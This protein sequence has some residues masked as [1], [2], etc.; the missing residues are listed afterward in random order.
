M[1]TVHTFTVKPSL[2]EQ[3]KDLQ[4]IVRNLY[5]TWHY[6]ITEIFRRIDYDLWKQCIH[7]PVKMLGMVSQARLEDLARNE[8][9][10]YQLKQA[11]E[12]LEK[13]LNAPSW[14]NKIYAREGH[15]TLIAYFCAEFGIHESM[16]IYSGGLGMLSGDHLKSASDL[17]I[18]LVGVGLMY[19]KGYFRQ[20]LNTDGWQQEH[21]ID[22]DFHNMPLELVQKENGHPVL[23][24]IQF[25]DR[26]VQAQIW[27]AMI[28]RTPLYLL[29]T[30]LTV[31]SFHD[32]TITQTLY[33]G[34]SEMRICQEIVLGIGG[35][36]ALFA[37]GLEPTVCHMNEG[38]AAFMAL[39]RVRKLRSRY[40]MTFE[41]ALEAARASN[42]FTVHTPVAAGND[43]FPVEMIDKYFSHYYGTLGINR[44]QFLALGRVHP[45]DSH[46][47]FKMPV[48][49]LRTSTYR[50]GV[51]QL[52]GEV[53][54]KIW[55]GLWPELPVSE[56]P[57]TSIT[58]GI[59]AKTWL[60]P[61]LNSLYE[62][63]LGSRWADE[64]VDKSIWHNLDQVPDEEL[65][66]IH[67][68][69]KER[70]V[71]FARTRL[72]R[73]LQRRG[74]FHTELSWAEEV[75]DP[76]ALTIGFARR[77]ATYKRGN[78]LLREPQ[79]LIKLLSNTETPVQF[80]FA[81]KAHPRDTAGKEIIRQLVHFASE[82]PE[83]RRRLIF[84]EDY[85]MDIARYLVQGVDVWLNNPRRPMEASGTSGMKAAI[86]GVLNMSTLDGWWC[87][88]YIPDGGWIIG[89]GEEYDD[90]SYQ[91]QVESQA[92][93]NLLEQEVVPLFF[94][95]GKDRLPRRWIR[96]MKNTIKWCA[97]RFNTS[98]MV[99]EYTRRFYHPADLRWQELTANE[100]ERV[101][102][103]SLWK[104]KIRQ[105][106]SD[107]QIRS[108]ETKTVDGEPVGDYGGK[109]PELSVGSQVQVQSRVH[110]GRLE[111]TDISVQIYYGRVDSS[112]Q[113]KDGQI[114]EM[115]YVDNSLGP[116]RVGQ[117]SGTIPCR[118]SGQRGFA[119]RIL[120]RHPDLVE[121]Y[122]SG[123][124]LWET[125]R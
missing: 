104:Q 117:F 78:L 21:Y 56:I 67:Q 52:H 22:N 24:G 51:S 90:L 73:Q 1:Q 50:N 26:T 70:L 14:F 23:I 91:D 116:E 42:V 75:L 25:P 118:I 93:Y 32:R 99:A 29:D 5:W 84:L 45:N 53:S 64:A 124:V 96:R 69:G 47:S 74:A 98:R 65:W 81:G 71:A 92:I 49:A 57:I 46:E 125:G 103:L 43:E 106:W 10:L 66:R 40:N 72:K 76:E 122:E 54:R 2:P 28:G 12:T 19:Q 38:H 68:R 109:Q 44:E 82:N 63:Y 39:E 20:Y 11:R 83:I 17:G 34:D 41:E 15:K 102:A 89:A 87:E 31:N 113:I 77:F 6:D 55:S 112:G 108:V 101:K 4:V 3:L 35:L 36:K 119:L 111:P 18:P 48:L 114:S 79:R 107:L 110:L 115:A 80:I 13:T 95:R 33:G 30:N 37:L 60:S 8:G 123:L 86:N 7:N 59:H 100:M 88:G 62:R 85:D 97:P 105:S 120:P 94:N 16:P 61:E 58:N 9:F 27:K 121:P